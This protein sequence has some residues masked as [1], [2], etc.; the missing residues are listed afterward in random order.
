MRASTARRTPRRNPPAGTN[1]TVRR[2]A[3]S[4]VSATSQVSGLVYADKNKD[5]QAQDN[6]PRLKGISVTLR[7]TDAGGHRVFMRT[8]TDDGGIYQFN[9]LPAGT[10]SISV[11]TPPGYT[12]GG[13]TTGAFGGSAA[14]NVVSNISIPQGQSSGGY[15]FGEIVMNC[16]W[17]PPTNGCGGGWQSHGW[18]SRRW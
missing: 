17:N 7:G 1:G 6:E 5:G 13:S 11:N 12:A 10:Y 16:A 9:N 14:P 18:N 3:S 2:Q 15:N 4:A 8:R